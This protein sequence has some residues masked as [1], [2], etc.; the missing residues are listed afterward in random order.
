MR[1][2]ITIALTANA[3]KED[4]QKSLAAGCSDHLTRS[5]HKNRLLKVVS[6]Y[7]TITQQCS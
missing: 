3:L 4:R 5:I 2:G 1:L 7:A 6:G